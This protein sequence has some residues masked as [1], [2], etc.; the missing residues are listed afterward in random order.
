M[1]IKQ[2]KNWDCNQHATGSIIGLLGVPDKGGYFEVRDYC[3]AGV[4]YK[5]EIG[6]GIDTTVQ[7]DIWTAK[8][9]VVLVS[10]LEVGQEASDAMWLLAKWLQ[11]SHPDARWN[12]LAAN[13]QRLIICGDSVAKNGSLDEVKRDSYRTKQLNL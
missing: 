13:V 1:Q 2:G 11:G 12:K 9:L 4:A 7:G 5:S 3:Y 10:G 6:R 8:N